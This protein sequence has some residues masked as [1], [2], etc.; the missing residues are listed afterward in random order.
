[1]DQGT[2]KKLP[3][4]ESKKKANQCF[5]WMPQSRNDMKCSTEGSN[6]MEAAKSE[7]SAESAMIGESGKECKQLKSGQDRPIRKTASPEEKNKLMASLTAGGALVISQDANV[8]GEVASVTQLSPGR[9]AA[10]APSFQTQPAQGLRKRKPE[11]RGLTNPLESINEQGTG[12]FD[13]E[14]PATSTSSIP[15]PSNLILVRRALA[16]GK[17]DIDEDDASFQAFLREQRPQ[18]EVSGTV[19]TQNLERTTSQIDDGVP[20]EITEDH[21]NLVRQSLLRK[22]G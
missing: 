5:A 2:S 19:D 10:P 14:N 12:G 8:A 15:N 1:M 13:D 22:K 3:S 21:I 17:M 7:P 16:L 4:A 11:N 6:T 20:M 18:S 9:P